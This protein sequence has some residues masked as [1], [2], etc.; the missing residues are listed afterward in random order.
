MPN[1][2]DRHRR[3]ISCLLDSQYSFSHLH[4]SDTLRHPLMPESHFTYITNSI[5]MA[6]NVRS[7]VTS[8]QLLEQ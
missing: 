2:K 6:M 5:I 3:Y 8:A 7:L 1:T 4:R